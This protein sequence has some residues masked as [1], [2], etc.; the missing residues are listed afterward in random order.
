MVVYKEKGEIIYKIE[1]KNST[2]SNVT[3]TYK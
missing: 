3:Y 1:I 2:L